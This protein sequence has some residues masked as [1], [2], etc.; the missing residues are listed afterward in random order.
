MNPRK[1]HKRNPARKVISGYGST[2]MNP[3]RAEETQPIGENECRLQPRKKAAE[4]GNRIC[5]PEEQAQNESGRDIRLGKSKS[6]DE[7][8]QKYGTNETKDKSPAENAA[9]PPGGIVA[10]A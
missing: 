9:A 1:R 2:V 7:R 3:R 8:T 5:A 6:S 4:E 10:V